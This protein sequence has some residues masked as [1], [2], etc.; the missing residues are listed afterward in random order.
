[1]GMGQSRIRSADV[2]TVLANALALVA[3]LFLLWKLRT[4]VAWTLVALLLALAADPAVDFLARHRVRRGFGV[5]I[6]FVLIGGLLAALV[7][8]LVPMLISQARALIDRAPDLIDSVRHAA[9]VRWA[10]EHFN[11]VDRV[12]QALRE[13]RMQ[14]AGSAL[15]VA[16]SIVQGMVG[17]I[18][19]FALTVFML[20][21]G[22]EVVDKI[23][24]WAPPDKRKHSRELGVKMRRVVG[25]YV[26]GTLLV[27]A[28][29]GTVMGITT[30]ILGVPYFLAL[31]L[32]MVVLGLIPFLGGTLGALLVVGVTFTSSG[33]KAG[34]IAAGVYL[35]Y[36]QIENQV[37]Q[38][39]VQRRT[40]S[41]NPLFITLMLLAGTFLGGVIG[42][43]LALPIAGATQVILQGALSRRQAQWQQDA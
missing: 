30:A 27:A 9:P 31:G 38:P 12:Q 1:M 29:G 24:A 4:L 37:L 23:L 5:L 43:L 36:Q 3:T 16:S 11:L 34:L 15:A 41:M 26:L 25:G 39:L 28:V 42:T 32:V 10:N 13:H 18:T 22:E 2:W 40:I 33:L 35:V 17:A 14:A 8:T 7:A 6:V 19:I 20:L 21:F